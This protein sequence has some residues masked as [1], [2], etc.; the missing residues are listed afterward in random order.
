[1]PRRDATTQTAEQIVDAIVQ[2]ATE[3][4]AECGLSGLTTNHIAK[5]AG[6]SIGS[7]YRYFPS[8]E[9]IV[10]ELDVRYRRE[11]AEE[12][13]VL[14]EMFERDFRGALRAALRG[15]VELSGQRERVRRAVMTEVPLAW[16]QT[17]AAEIWSSVIDR[18][19]A[20]ILR[21]RPEL[22]E[23]EAKLR[24][25][26]VLHAVQGV[27]MGLVVWPISEI[28]LEPVL[29]SLESIVTGCLLG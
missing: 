25:F 13:A 9:A 12:L 29:A 7:V 20:T 24:A 10:A 18:V 17:H 19:S 28:A 14:L 16:I 8:K 27:T 1:M 26:T 2:A 23:P 15:F 11:A 3:L 4:F 6:V 5:R 22:G 21:I